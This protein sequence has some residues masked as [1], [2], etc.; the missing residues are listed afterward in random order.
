MTEPNGSAKI[1]EKIAENAYGKII[2]RG[3]MILCGLFFP[4]TVMVAK[5]YF[6]DIRA[7]QSLAI[8][9]IDR[10]N[11]H[12]IDI[13][14]TVLQLAGRVSGIEADRAKNVPFRYSSR[15]AAADFKLRDL[16]DSEQDRRL[17]KAEDRLDDHDRRLNRV[18]L[19]RPLS[20]SPLAP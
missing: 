6:D 5:S 16:K 10:I 8:D 9:K 17:D 20:V 4:L 1:A 12:N 14:K 15:D 11:N 3:S 18:G 7:T 13:D 19:S 2:A